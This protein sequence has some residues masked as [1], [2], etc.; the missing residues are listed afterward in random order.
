M[1]KMTLEEWK[2]EAVRRFGKNPHDWKFKC[3]QCGNVQTATD[4]EGLV[5]DPMS[6]MFFSCLGRWKDDVG[7]K[8]TLGGLLRMHSLEVDPGDGRDPIPSFEFA[9]TGDEA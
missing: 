8:W 4:F 1:K 2:A 7:C 9:E 5:E 3:V 6:T